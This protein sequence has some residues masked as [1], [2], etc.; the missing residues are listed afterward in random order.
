MDTYGYFKILM[1]S[2]CCI[3]L[4][5]IS[6]PPSAQIITTV[7]GNGTYGYSGDGGPAIVAQLGDMYY[8]YPAFDSYG[9]MY[10]SQNNDNTIR[11]ID[12]S[13]I[14]TTIA[15]TKGVIGYTGDGGPAVNSLL[16]HPTS[17]AVDNNNNIY[18]ADRNGDVLRKIDP[19]GII[20]TVS[21]QYTVTCGVGDG[22][23]LAQAQFEAISG[24]TFDKSNNLYIADYGCNTI[25]KVNTSGIITTIAGNGTL[26]YSGDGGTATQAQLAYPCTVAVDNA[27]NVYIPDSQ[28][29]R[30]RKV[31]TTGI[32]TTI[33]GT[34]VQGYSGDG[35]PAIDAEIAFPGSVVIDNAGNLYFGGYNDVIR[36]IDVSG[37]ITTYAGNGS[38]GYSGDGGPAILASL[39]ETEGRISI[40]NNDIF[41]ANYQEGNVIRK[42]SN[43][44][45][46]S[47]SQQPQNIT[48]CNPGNAIFSIKATNLTG[49]QW[50]LN[51]G[52]E[53]TNL[54]NNSI[55]SGT[56]TNKL[57]VTGA[58]TGMNNFQYRCILSNGCG[59]IFSTV[60]SLLINTAVNPSI[61]VTT[62]SESICEGAS[63]VF[64]ATV[65]NEG[66][67]PSYKWKKNGSNVGTNSNS[68]SDN[69]LINGDIIS[70]TLTSDTTCSISNTA[71]SNSIVVTVSK[72]V[73]PTVAV[74][75]S[76]NN[77]CSGTP[78]KFSSTVTNGGTTPFLQWQKNG[79]NTGTNSH[80]YIDSA[81]KDGDIITCRL[82]SDYFCASADTIVSNSII[83][84]I[85]PLVDPSVAIT[86]SKS[87]ICPG[88]SVTFNGTTDNGGTSLV[89]QWTKNGISVGL[90]NNSYTDASLSDGDVVNCSVT[91]DAACLASATAVSNP[92][93]IAVFQNPIVVLDKTSTLCSGSSRQLDAGNFDS[94][95]WNNGTMERTLLVSNAGTYSVIV[96]DKNGCKGSDTTVI[97]QVFTLPQNFIPKDTSICSYGTITLK[98]SDGFKNYLWSNNSNASFITVNQAGVYSLQVTDYNLCTA[99]ETV[100]VSLKQCMSG[101]YIP[102]AFTPNNDGKN[103]LFKP[104]VFGNVK[105]Y[106]FT[107][108]NRFGQKIFQTNNV[109]MGWDGTLNGI[110]QQ[111]DVFVW[112]C[113]YQ[114]EG[115]GV[116]NKK[117]TVMLI[118]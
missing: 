59:S 61:A 43:C 1:R 33:A 53:W 96:T 97:N 85:R 28:N 110:A 22:G 30:I 35:G 6:Y 115:S 76:A 105:A 25:R 31:S 5:L 10:I 62:P 118:R 106:S 77:I 74:S 9:N 69:A 21:G 45:T 73:I 60:A 86:A 49:Y 58:T 71:A 90:N 67:S 39:S 102:N 23:P 100:T 103:D 98:A 108:Y 78:V 27:G 99:T 38:Y 65:Q 91:S 114:L 48:L 93:R 50:Q 18:F 111:A 17:I 55:Y 81:F 75:A 89:Y 109:N 12:V 112:T 70:C 92:I 2:A 57:A 3:F 117:G 84:K 63:V 104:L 88:N 46:A 83:M 72:P 7:A 41:F 36:K 66:S 42:I 8:C 15:G 4:L 107:V 94:Y 34:G 113:T 80:D 82:A 101:F 68:Y 54:S 16:Y 56:I 32:I 51:N 87:S 29:H 37:T 13:G 44:L 116:E 79:I 95:L 24:I 20:T 40:Y 19:S 26:G 52:T 11:K 47:I 64:V 14:I